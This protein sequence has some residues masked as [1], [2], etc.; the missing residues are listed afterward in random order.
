[1]FKEPFFRLSN[2]KILTKKESDKHTAKSL[3][4]SLDQITLVCTGVSPK[5]FQCLSKNNSETLS[6]AIQ[7]VNFLKA[8]TCY[9]SASQKYLKTGLPC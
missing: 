2:K 5:S 3:D 1:M 7:F 8:E 4:V 6:V 9:Y